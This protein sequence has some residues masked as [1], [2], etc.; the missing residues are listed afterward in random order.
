MEKYDTYSIQPSGCQKIELHQNFRSRSETLEFTNDVFYKIMRKDLGNVTYD[1]AA[2]LYPGAVYPADDGMRPEL[3]LADASEE[4]LED[5][6]LT[7]P[8]RLEAEVAAA[9]IRMLMRSQKVTD[10]STGELRAVRYSDIVILLRSFGTYA[11]TFLEVFEQK[12]IPAHASS[13]TGYFQTQEIQTI[14]SL[15]RILDNPRQDI[16]LASVMRSPIGGFSDEELA[17]LKA[18]GK[19]RSFHSCVLQPETSK[20]PEKLSEKINKFSDM[21]SRF[22]DLVPELPI[23]ELLYRILEET[24]YAGYAAAMPGGA[25]RKANIEMLLEKAIAYEQSSYRGLFHFIRYMDQ[26]QKYEVDYGEADV[27]S[28]NANAVRLMTIH[29]SKGLEFP[30]VF[31][32]GTAKKFNRQD[33]RSSMVIH[34]E[35]GIGVDYIDPGLRVKSATLYKKAVARQIELENQ[36]EELRV[37][38]VALTR[39]KEKLI[40]T[41]TAKRLKETVAK[42]RLRGNSGRAAASFLERAKADCFLDWILP[43]VTAYGDKYPVSIWGV[44]D[45]ILEETETQLTHA[46]GIGELLYQASLPDDEADAYVSRR[47]SWNYPYQPETTRKVKYSVSELKHRAMEAVFEEEELFECQETLIRE[48][49][50]DSYVPRFAGGELEINRGALRGSAM[51]RA[52]ECLSIERLTDSGQPEEELDQEIAR[53]V[54][55]GLLTEDMEALLERG[56]LTAFYRSD[57]ARRMKRASKCRE[58]YREKPFVMG[59]K[60]DEVEHDGSSTMVLIQGIIDAFFL[61]GDEIVLLDYKTDAVASEEELVKRY[62]EQLELYQEALEKNLN[63]KVKEKLIYSFHFDKTIV[64]S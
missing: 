22:R 32:C 34:P 46:G 3:L 61:E 16:P 38:Y 23:H 2:A 43:A 36:G 14:L 5:A 26:L 11:D 59:K 55:E 33:A 31:L 53:I 19:N 13:K 1:D 24:G 9:K 51:H 47:L 17:L 52:L 40:V 30:V 20:L 15:L 48:E 8:V 35:L 63:K 42:L 62:R 49:A 18:A 37:L 50:Q 10:S 21:L 7:D 57:L 12:K 58:L 56:K 60:A 29:K 54:S 39:A 6:G 45:L 41:G 28:E 25:R 4:L 64:V 44:E 27:V